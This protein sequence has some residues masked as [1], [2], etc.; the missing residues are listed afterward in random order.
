MTDSTHLL[1][2]GK[3][4]DLGDGPF[5]AGRRQVPLVVADP[6]HDLA[7]SPVGGGENFAPD[8]VEGVVHEGSLSVLVDD[9][10]LGTH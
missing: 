3:L 6:G 5:G 2:E 8:G 4:H 1:I 10:S 7:Q 9:S